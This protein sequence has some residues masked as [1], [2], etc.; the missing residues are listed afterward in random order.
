MLC[1]PVLKVSYVILFSDDAVDTILG[2]P[3]CSSSQQRLSIVSAARRDL[4]TL[5]DNLLQTRQWRSMHYMPILKTH[6]V[7]YRED[8]IPPFLS[9]DAYWQAWI[10]YQGMLVTKLNALTYSMCSM[11]SIKTIMLRMFAAS[12]GRRR[13]RS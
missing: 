11:A 5:T 3:T 13:R 4:S 6:G 9:K 10:E 2:C 12:H 8:G 7:T 1:R